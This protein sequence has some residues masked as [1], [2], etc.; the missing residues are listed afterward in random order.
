M[1]TR[2]RSLAL[3]MRCGL[4]HRRDQVVAKTAHHLSLYVQSSRS[5]L[6]WRAFD[7]CC[8]RLGVSFI[9][10]PYHLFRARAKTKQRWPMS[11]AGYAAGDNIDVLHNLPLNSFMARLDLNSRADAGRKVIH[12]I[13]Y[14]MI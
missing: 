5:I 10:C 2:R 11:G 9:T 8:Q 1:D 6:V 13:F 14:W 7:R 4:F 3:G 12:F